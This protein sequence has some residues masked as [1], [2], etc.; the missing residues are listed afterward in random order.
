MPGYAFLANYTTLL[1]TFVADRA[2]WG[3]IVA[4]CGP[5]VFADEF[6]NVIIP[7]PPPPAPVPLVKTH[8]CVDRR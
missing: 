5:F 7:A 6:C 2:P 3:P 8:I 4:P 1:T